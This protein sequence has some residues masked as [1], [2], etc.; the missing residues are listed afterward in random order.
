MPQI[1][2]FS[3]VGGPK[4]W[5]WV[6]FFFFGLKSDPKGSIIWGRVRLL[7]TPHPNNSPPPPRR[8]LLTSPLHTPV[9]AEQTRRKG[10]PKMLGNHLGKGIKLVQSTH[11]GE[12][13]LTFEKSA[14]E[15]GVPPPV[16]IVH[17]KKQFLFS[18]VWVR[19]PRQHLFKKNRFRRHGNCLR[20]SVPNLLL[21]K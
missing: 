10:S 5:G 9:K 1:L 13:F 8:S 19:F 3:E 12:L 4:F 14:S 6:M 16:K 18:C 11:A 7:G 15:N 17:F 20:W 2:T 21:V